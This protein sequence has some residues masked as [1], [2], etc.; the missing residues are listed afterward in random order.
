[1][2]A[3][4][5]AIGTIGAAVVA[6]ALGLGF[7]EWVFRPRLR[8]RFSPGS[9]SDQVVT[10]TVGGEPAGYIRLHVGNDGR[11]SANRVRVSLL[12]V[13]RWDDERGWEHAKPEIDGADLV[14]SNRSEEPLDIPP[15]SERPLDLFAIVRDWDAQ[16]DM[17]MALQIGSKVPANRADQLSP[18]AWRVKLEASADN[19]SPQTC[20]VAFRFDG[21]WPGGA[22]AAIWRAVTVRGPSTRPETDPPPRPELP[23]PAE[24]LLEVLHEDEEREE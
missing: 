23:G 8:I 13:E 6:L 4:L 1:M 2:T 24:L 22:P 21:A 19:A 11:A 10:G 18:G 14:W 12:Q 3:W 17:P 15:R 5:T 16:G 9:I 7:K 20:Y